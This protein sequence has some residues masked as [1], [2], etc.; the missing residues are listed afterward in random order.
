[1]LVRRHQHGDVDRAV[2]LGAED[3][4]ALVEQDGQLERVVDDEVADLGA[5]RELLDRDAAPAA[6]RERDV[7]ELGR[8]VGDQREHAQR[9]H[10]VGVGDGQ[11]GGELVGERGLARGGGGHRTLLGV[12]NS[13]RESRAVART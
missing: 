10:D 12:G 11:R 13:R 3:L 2:L 6:L 9:P 4:L 5:G 1:M 7:V 8:A